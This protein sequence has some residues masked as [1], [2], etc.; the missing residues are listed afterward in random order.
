MRPRTESADTGPHRRRALSLAA[1]LA[2]AI[3]GLVLVASGVVLTLALTV[4]VDTTTDL[5]AGKAKVVVRGL[6]ARIEEHL[7]PAEA[8]VD[9]VG[10]RLERGELA[11][12]DRAALASALRYT[13]AGAPQ[14]GGAAVLSA[15]G[16]ALAA[17]RGPDGTVP[18]V[19]GRWDD[20]PHLRSAVAGLRGS[21]SGWGPPLYLADRGETVLSYARAVRRNGVFLGGVVAM[22]PVSDLA[23]FTAELSRELPGQVFVLYGRD[24]VLAHPD[25]ERSGFRASAEEPVPSLDQLGDSRLAGIWQPGAEP[26][27]MAG[28]VEGHHRRMRGAGRIVQ[29]YT[30]LDERRAVPWFVGATFETG[31]FGRAMRRLWGA[32]AA[33]L[34]LTLLALAA[35]VLLARRL[36]RPVEDFARAAR[37]VSELRFGEVQPPARSPVRELDDAARAFGG[38]VTA[39]A[40]FARYVPRDLVRRLLQTGRGERPRRRTVTLMFTDLAGFTGLAETLE[41]EEVTRLLERHYAM[42]ADCIERTGGTVDKFMGDGVMAFWGAP[43]AVPDHAERAVRAARA[44]A[45]EHLAMRGDPH[46]LPLRIG[47]HT[48]EA[49]VGEIAT[50]A[51]VNDTVTGDTVNTASRLQE[52]VRDILGAPAVGALVSETTVAAVADRAGLVEVGA[53]VPRGRRSA[54]RL[55]ALA[56]P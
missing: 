16:W 12:D 29:L 2:L 44:M 25:L 43:E 22:L 42:L 26:M 52:A 40:A 15:E 8:L 21:G 33:G 11:F 17:A 9:F 10:A 54:L 6:A 46:F 1:L 41:P 35:A 37:A 24:R 55:W 19:S 51:R 45:R 47:V 49:L 30:R 20:E 5:L 4:A 3:G 28:P 38:M 31:D 34:G 56:E 23:A 53:H 18:V 32:G 39:L 27:P 7:R 50:E 14:L 48:G 36:A 13:L